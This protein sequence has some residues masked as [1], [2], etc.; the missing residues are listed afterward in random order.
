MKATAIG[1]V[2]EWREVRGKRYLKT[3]DFPRLFFAGKRHHEKDASIPFLNC[4]K[5]AGGNIKKGFGA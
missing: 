4:R 5:G 1:A 2:R 3:G